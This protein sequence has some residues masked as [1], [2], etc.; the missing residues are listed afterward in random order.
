[1][2]KATQAGK[3]F[4]TI[5]CLAPDD[6]LYHFWKGHEFPHADMEK[7]LDHIAADVREK[8]YKSSTSKLKPKPEVFQW[9]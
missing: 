1:M 5:T 3:Y 4:I 2:A 6:K 9:T 7:S 8:L